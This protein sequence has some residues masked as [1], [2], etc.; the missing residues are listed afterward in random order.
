MIVDV[1]ERNAVAEA[2][3]LSDTSAYESTSEY[4]PP[5]VF[6]GSSLYLYPATNDPTSNPCLSY[7]QHLAFTPPSPPEPPSPPSPPALPPFSPPRPPLPPLAPGWLHRR[8]EGYYLAEG[9]CPNPITD[10]SECETAAALF[11]STEIQYQSASSSTYYPPYCYMH[12]P[13]PLPRLAR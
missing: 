2:L 11:G 13:V 9:N 8:P 12:S 5:A 3:G 7:E 6:T 10:K 1:D 4:Y